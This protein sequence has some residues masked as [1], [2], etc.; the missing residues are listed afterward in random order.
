MNTTSFIVSSSHRTNTVPHNDWHPES[1]ALVLRGLLPLTTQFQ[2]CCLGGGTV[3]RAC[4]ICKWGPVRQTLHCLLIMMCL[5]IAA[6]Y[7]RLCNA[8]LRDSFLHG[9]L[10]GHFTAVRSWQPLPLLTHHSQYALSGTRETPLLPTCVS[11]TSY[12]F[13]S[14]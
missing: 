5:A 7:I 14:N 11:R 13:D 10:K 1:I 9:K 6:N 4:S 3:P 8:R 12:H 2:V